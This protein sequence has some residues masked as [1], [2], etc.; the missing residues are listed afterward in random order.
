MEA[1]EAALLIIQG[2]LTIYFT[3]LT[4]RA[5]VLLFFAMRYEKKLRSLGKNEEILARKPFVTIMIP[6][7]NEKDIVERTIESCLS[8][9]YD[10]FEI[11]VVDDSTDETVEILKKWSKHPKVRVIHRAERKGWKGGA[12]DEGLKHVDP[13]TEFLLVVDADQVVPRSIIKKMLTRFTNDRV[14]AVQGRSLSILN[15]DENW[16]TMAAR[17]FSTLGFAVEHPGRFA[18]GGANPLSGSTMMVRK[19]VLEEVGGFGDSITE[20]YDLTLRIYLHGYEVVY[21]DSVKSLTEC[22]STAWDLMKQMCRWLE[23]RVRNFKKRFKDIIKSDKLSLR[24]KLDLMLECLANTAAIAAVLGGLC[25]FISF[26][27]GVQV[28]S[29][30]A[31]LGLPDPVQLAFSTYL[32]VGYPLVV[33]AALKKEGEKRTVGWLISFFLA[34]GLAVP[35]SLGALLRGAFANTGYFYR[36]VKTGRITMLGEFLS[37][38]YVM[39]GGVQAPYGLE[40]SSG[41][42]LLA[43]LFTRPPNML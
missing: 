29:F 31:F 33:F 12:L 41:L 3:L 2:F 34:M 13:R 17:T 39:R 8:V 18:M 36:T 24:K 25:W 37:E 27:T 4:T 19:D 23:G 15:A 43:G 11:L 6:C 32:L 26:L 30:L 5:V 7:Y 21:D 28:P 1:L 22:P 35:F 14:A 20:D 40:G 38:E 10:N 9:D 16:V 42:G